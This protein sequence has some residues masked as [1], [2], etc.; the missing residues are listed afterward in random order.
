MKIIFSRD[1]GPGKG[2]VDKEILNTAKK[3]KEQ[4]EIEW[5][6]ML[7][8]ANDTKEVLEV[9]EKIENKLT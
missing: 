2:T 7:N 5:L 1:M 4:L 9:L 6:R 8:N 3:S